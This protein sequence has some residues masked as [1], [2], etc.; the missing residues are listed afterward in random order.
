M[1]HMKIAAVLMAILAVAMIVM[2][3]NMAGG[4]TLNPPMVTGLGFLVIAYVFCTHDHNH[5]H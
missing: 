1:K 4:L 5:T 3:Y 2:G